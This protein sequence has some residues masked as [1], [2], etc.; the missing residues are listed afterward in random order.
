MSLTIAS[1]IREGSESLKSVSDTARLDTELL[2]MRVTGLHR[3]ELI[4][5]STRELSAVEEERF[6]A[7][8]NRRAAFE[9]VAYLIGKR[10]FWGLDFEVNSD[11]LVPRPET[12]LIIETA[13]YVIGERTTPVRI[14]DL[15]TGSGAIAVALA[16]ECVNRRVSA[17][18]VAVD[19]SPKALC[20]AERNA[21]THGVRSL[22]TFREG[23]WWSAIKP[24]E[25]FDLIVTNPPYVEAHA[26]DQ[27]PTLRWE[28]RGALAAGADGLDAIKQIVPGVAGRLV[29]HGTFLCEI[30]SGQKAA[31]SA[32]LKGTSPEL[33]AKAQ[34]LPD[35]AG[36][37][38]VLELVVE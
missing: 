4:T 32:W 20:V 1:A 2:L 37:D 19:V 31:I 9:P 33:F 36:R 18:I 14:L 38:R 7:L 15:G 16:H 26:V 17:E 8:L 25:R 27:S 34:F 13:I 3:V 10:E 6:R 12:E 28:P 22:I 30:G 35:L 5:K 24:D 21:E 29:P 11:V 23:N